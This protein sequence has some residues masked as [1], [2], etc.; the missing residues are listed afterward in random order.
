MKK[1]VIILIVVLLSMTVSSCTASGKPEALVELSCGKVEYLNYRCTLPDGR[2]LLTGGT[3]RDEYGG[4]AAWIMCLNTDR[5][6]SWEYISRK[7]GYTSAE[8]ATVLTDGTVAVIMEDYPRKRAVMFFT[9]DGKKARK[10]LDLKKKRGII[11]TITP[12][13]IMSYDD[14]SKKAEDYR[15]KT[16]LYDWKGKEINRYD[17][18][19]MKDGYGYIV[20]NND[21]YVFFGHDAVFNGHAMIQK[22]D[23]S[24][25]KVLWET[26]MDWQLSGSD[27]AMLD[28][29][30]KTSDGGYV[31][32]LREGCPGE[33]EWSSYEWAHFLVKF[34]ADGRLLWV[35][36]KD[37]YGPDTGYLFLHDGKIGIFCKDSLQIDASSYI[38]WL[39]M[40]GNKLGNTEVKL[41]PDDF[42]VLRDYMEPETAEEKRTTIMDQQ[43]FIPMDDGLW[44]MATCFAANDHG[45]EGF[46]TI[47]DSQ[48][49][50]MF[51]IPET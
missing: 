6:I 28:Y 36:G 50:V 21:E 25:D 45:E 3:R 8:E 14:V 16:I 17:G 23:G 27:T 4:D 49:I 43:Q 29:A 51:K 13:F 31:A 24:L 5:T 39:D 33:N 46:S 42:R 47:F 38:C 40:D 48:E 10:K 9:P 18:L 2:L 22:L 11:Y 35:K 1:F 20:P 32:W 15:Y 26:R 19:I 37:E 12:S 41:N 7:D 30:L 34:D 44:V